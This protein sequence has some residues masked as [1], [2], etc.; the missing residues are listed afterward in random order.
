MTPG[1]WKALVA[2][3]VGIGLVL[4][5]VWL[6]GT[7]AEA[8]QADVLREQIKADRAA[9]ERANGIAQAAEEQLEAERQK[10]ADLNRKW[11]QIRESKSRAVCAL[12]D[13]TVSLLR[14]ATSPA[15]VPER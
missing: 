15:S 8:A 5:G 1:L 11:S 6:K 14:D 3:A 13:D 12:D 4:G 2:A 7:M 10:S 9:Q